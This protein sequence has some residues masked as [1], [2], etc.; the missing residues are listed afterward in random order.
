MP[1]FLPLPPRS[2]KPRANGVTHVI[3]MGLTAAGARALVQSAGPFVD[4]VRLGWGSAYVT[5][6]LK[7]KL[8]AYREGGVPVMLG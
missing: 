2:S 4:I 7:A 3:D 6:D 1:D 8:T 5:A